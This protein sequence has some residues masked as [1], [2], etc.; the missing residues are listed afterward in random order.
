MI[1]FSGSLGVKGRG[2]H[3][4][5]ITRQKRNTKRIW[6]P[7]LT[8]FDVFNL[9][10]TDSVII[11]KK[12]I[13]TEITNYIFYSVIILIILGMSNER[14]YQVPKS[15]WPF[16]VKTTS[17]AVGIISDSRSAI[18]IN[19]VTGVTVTTLISF[20]STLITFHG[21][22]ITSAVLAVGV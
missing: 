14:K 9:M 13:S 4:N 1:S 7:K 6:A 10:S 22:H 17:E 15:S 19:F 5:N 18:P 2:K 8:S 21:H 16:F 12:K 3:N 11:W 20:I